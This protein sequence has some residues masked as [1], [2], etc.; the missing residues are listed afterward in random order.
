MMAHKAVMELVFYKAE[1]ALM[2]RDLLPA[3]LTNRDGGV[4]PPV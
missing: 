3:F 2:T 1:I 4:T